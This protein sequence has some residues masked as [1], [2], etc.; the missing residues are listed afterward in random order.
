[1]PPGSL[2]LCL[3]ADHDGPW[4]ARR[5]ELLIAKR[6]VGCQND[7]RFTLP[8]GFEQIFNPLTLEMSRNRL[9]RV[10]HRFDSVAIQF[11]HRNPRGVEEIVEFTLPVIQKRDGGNDETWWLVREFFNEPHQKVRICSVFP[12]PISSASRQPAVS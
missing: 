5:G 11:H 3:V 7:F 9:F 12:S 6:L 8:A 10:F 4:L 1:M 2:F